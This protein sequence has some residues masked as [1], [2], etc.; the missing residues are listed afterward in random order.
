MQ[1][2]DAMRILVGSFTVDGVICDDKGNLVHLFNGDFE[3]AAAEIDDASICLSAQMSGLAIGD[4]YLARRLLE[5]NLS[6]V[7]TG[8]G[9]MAPDPVGSGLYALVEMVHLGPLNADDFRLRVVDFMLYVEYW[10]AEG[11][12]ALRADMRREAQ[13]RAMDAGTVVMRG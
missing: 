1:S 11:I 6:G 7:E 13:A 5:A 10:R 3:F 9:A 2:S 12:P 8:A 4:P